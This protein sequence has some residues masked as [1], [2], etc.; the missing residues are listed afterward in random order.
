[1][2]SEMQR[3]G[4]KVLLC[5]WQWGHV[6]DD[7]GDRQQDGYRDNNNIIDKQQYIKRD[8][9]HVNWIKV[10]LYN[11]GALIYH[12]LTFSNINKN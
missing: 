5:F 11:E 8:Y 10:K 7:L 4:S 3:K 1:M 2:G 6:R 9:C 12:E